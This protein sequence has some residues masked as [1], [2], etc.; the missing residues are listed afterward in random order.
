M[1]STSM[2]YECMVW[3]AS[4]KLLK[5]HPYFLEK[6]IVSEVKIF[7]TQIAFQNIFAKLE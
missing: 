3:L 1:W 7:F 2:K 5:I 6:I 4:I